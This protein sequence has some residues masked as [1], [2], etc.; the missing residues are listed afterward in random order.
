MGT[1]LIVAELVHYWIDISAIRETCLAD[2]RAMYELDGHSVF[3]EVSGREE[4]R[5]YLVAFYIV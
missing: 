1:L 4:E 5:I 2:K 3:I